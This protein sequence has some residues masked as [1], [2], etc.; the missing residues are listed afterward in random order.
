MAH[1]PDRQRRLVRLLT[2]D[3]TFRRSAK[4]AVRHS[5]QRLRTTFDSLG[6]GVIATDPNH[7]V[8]RM[9]SR[10]AELAGMAATDTLG[11]HVDDVL[12]LFDADGRLIKLPLEPW[13]PTR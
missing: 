6:E 2:V 9:N 13:R 8:A 10:A 1:L 5:E 4:E 11:L 7:S 3:V 12:R